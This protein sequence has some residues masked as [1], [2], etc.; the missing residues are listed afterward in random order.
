MP[1][2]DTLKPEPLIERDFRCGFNLARIASRK[3]LE[4]LP[5]TTSHSIRMGFI[6]YHSM[7]TGDFN[8]VDEIS[9]A[10]FA[11]QLNLVPPATKF[12]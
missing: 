5:S 8:S 1:D 3:V 12:G 7:L 6:A 2:T 10:E 9:A 11:E 4:G